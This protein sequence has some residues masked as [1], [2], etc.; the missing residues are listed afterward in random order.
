MNRLRS[1]LRTAEQLQRA[2][3]TLDDGTRARPV[4]SWTGRPDENRDEEGNAEKVHKADRRQIPFY[5]VECR[6]RPC[7]QAGQPAP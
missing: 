6:V 3:T 5:L 2:P 4:K 7:E 1:T